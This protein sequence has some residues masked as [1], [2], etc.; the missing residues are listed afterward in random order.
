MSVA[1][2]E[3]RSHSEVIRLFCMEHDT[4]MDYDKTVLGERRRTARI[5]ERDT[6]DYCKVLLL[7]K[8]CMSEITLKGA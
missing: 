7:I 6:I 4:V 2:V 3:V 8:S 1:A 5:R